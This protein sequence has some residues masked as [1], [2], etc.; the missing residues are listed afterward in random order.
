M[1][2]ARVNMMP[3]A[4]PNSG[5]RDLE[6]MQQMPEMKQVNDLDPW[7]MKLDQ[8]G[9]VLMAS[10]E[11]VGSKPINNRFSFL[12]NLPLK[13]GINFLTGGSTGPGDSSLCFERKEMFA[14]NKASYY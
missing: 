7:V 10:K 11:T 2:L 6:I 12:M 1:E 8:C 3:M 9:G 5:P 4:P 13:W 14:L